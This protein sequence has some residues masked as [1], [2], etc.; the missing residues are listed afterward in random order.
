MFVSQIDI[1]LDERV[2][3]GTGI[4]SQEALRPLAYS[5]LA[6]L[7]HHVRNE[8]TIPQLTRVVHIYSCCLHEP[9]F[10]FGIQ[11]MCA[12]LLLNLIETICSKTDKVE[13][14]KFLMAILECCVDKLGAIDT[15]HEQLKGVY[16]KEAVERR[17][18]KGKA[19]A[20]ADGNDSATLAAAPAGK[21]DGKPASAAAKAPLFT[22]GAAKK[23]EQTPAL[24]L[25]D[26]PA[27]LTIERAKPVHAVSFASD[28]SDAAYSKDL[29]FLVD[30][31]YLIKT[32]LHGIR[33]LL[34]QL[35]VLGAA[36]PSGQLLGRLFESESRLL[37]FYDPIK[38][39]RD[40]KEALDLFVQILLHFD[41][42][43]FQEVWTTRMDFFV[44]QALG[45]GH[46]LTIPQSLLVPQN[47]QIP[48]LQDVSHQLV[49][50]LLKYLMARLESFGEQDKK[51]SALTLKLFKLA[52]MAVNSFPEH[53]EAVLVPHLAK[54]ITDSFSFAARATEPTIY[55]AILR[56]LFRS[57]GGGRFEALYKEVLP[58]LQEMLDTLNYLLLH[59]EPDRRDLFVELCLTVPVRLTNLLPH[60]GYLMKPL[61]HALR[62]GP[63]LVSQGL[64][65]LELCI[66]NLTSEFLDPTLGP[67]LRDLM[68][69]LHDLLKPVPFNHMH[70][71][72]TVKILGKL[73]GRNRRFQAVPHLLEYS[74]P[75]P[76]AVV[77]LSL[78]GHQRKLAIA[79]LTE[80]ALKSVRL[81]N[82]YYRAQAF[83]Y[84]QKSVLVF[85]DQVRLSSW[86]VCASP[87]RSVCAV[88]ILVPRY[89]VVSLAPSRR[90]S[91]SRRF[92]VFSTRPTTPSFRSRPSPS[93]ASSR[94]SSSPQSHARTRRRPTQR[95]ATGANAW[96]RSSRPSSAPTSRPSRL[97]SP[98]CPRLRP[99][100]GRRSS[101]SSS[102]TFSVRSTS[103]CRSRSG[104]I[105]RA[106]STR[107]A[108]G[109]RR[110]ALRNPGTGSSQAA[111]AS[112]S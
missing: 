93:S 37:A 11:T 58:I 61:V 91:S 104:P 72:A 31:R 49:A 15:I 42:H 103:R 25:E 10:T 112:R 56:A 109:S 67:V 106:C 27:W 50:I 92:R 51:N 110:S 48:H 41:N 24:E 23:D 39:S 78:D 6:D 111:P 95:P 26:Q 13:A 96:P 20:A 29:Y 94:A 12:K 84:L 73:G 88:L 18:A 32:L 102:T 82:E 33:A 17:R 75:A 68:G 66:D 99:P 34:N 60:L 53:N 8:L 71:H 64:R 70:A 5:M 79:P 77:P 57:I 21:D 81:P 89:R 1:M 40:E 3:V 59:A 9:A 45:N 80:L 38:D 62:A 76:E 83:D 28:G 44:Q 14:P 47:Q 22:A 86:P 69:A 74:P 55:Y 108:S 87:V 98:T 16:G 100:A 107:S 52:F 63:E 90:L 105:R 30:V 46:I 36:P 85:V 43:V 101:R 65:T 35:R 4:T 54:L 97:R 2:L 19:R 7:V